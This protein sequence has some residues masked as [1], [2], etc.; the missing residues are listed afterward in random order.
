V[1]E[2]G[3]FDIH[4]TPRPNPTQGQITFDGT[5]KETVY[6]PLWS[7]TL[8]ADYVFSTPVGTFTLNANAKQSDL[9]YTAV[10]NRQAIPSYIVENNSLKWSPTRSPYEIRLWVLKTFDKIYLNNRLE[11]ATGDWQIFAPPRTY[12]VL[13]TAKFDPNH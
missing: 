13:F 10:L 5:G 9:V 6:T 4:C 2:N 1:F 7:S 3:T 11:T 12:G 8:A